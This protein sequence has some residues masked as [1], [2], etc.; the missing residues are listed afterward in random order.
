MGGHFLD[1]IKNY[2]T[3]RKQRTFANG[4]TSSE[5]DVVCGVP[6][7]SILGPSLFLV[8]INDLRNVLK[9]CHSYLYA[10][11]TVVTLTGPCL[12]DLTQKMEEDL[13]LLSNW[14]RKNKLTL[15]TKKTNYII[16]GLRSKLKEIVNHKLRLAGT[17]IERCLSVKYLGIVLD[18]V[19]NFNMQAEVALKKLVYKSYMTA[20]LRDVLE[21]TTMINIYK[22]M[23]LPHADYGDIFYDIARKNILDKLQIIQNKSLRRCLGLDYLHPTILTHREAKLSQLHRRRVMHLYNFMFKQK[24][25]QDIVNL[26]DVRTRAHDAVLFTTIIPK[27]ETCKKSALYRGAVLWNDLSVEVR[28][29]DDFEAFKLNRRKW[30]GSTNY[31]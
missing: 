30:L 31:V 13:I 11:D 4:M 16:F 20:R 24:K 6:Q 23:V 25:N 10:D 2:I 21:N 26:R 18:Q 7:G 3:H 5:A 22:T 12:V 9:N 8:Y 17:P 29:I 19:L 27:N 1:W 14:F 28:L 15:N